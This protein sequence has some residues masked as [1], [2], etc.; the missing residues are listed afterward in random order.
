[1]NVLFHFTFLLAST[2][3]GPP[4]E[5][6]SP[7][8]PAV[9]KDAFLQ[10]ESFSTARFSCR[11]ERIEPGR[12]P[13]IRNWEY[14]IAKNGVH[15]RDH[16]D[17]DGIMLRRPTT[18]EAVLGWAGA[19]QAAERTWD[20]VSNESWLHRAGSKHFVVGSHATWMGYED[21]RTH[22]LRAI[23]VQYRTPRQHLELLEPLFNWK[24]SRA[25]SGLITVTSRGSD[26]SGGTHYEYEWGVDP[27]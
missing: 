6:S 9:L 18:G 5:D 22:G 7:N 13:M 27:E 2:N 8:I 23:D 12:A 14:E 3:A 15:A 1:M 4:S 10:R 11:M 17:D 16:G 25:K 26:H 19:A 20:F 24:T 21:I